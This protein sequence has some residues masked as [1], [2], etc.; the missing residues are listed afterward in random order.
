MFFGVVGFVVFGLVL[1]FFF[2]FLGVGVCVCLFFRDNKVSLV[3]TGI[4][5]F[6]GQDCQEVK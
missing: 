5:E 1:L 6:Q 2:S 3:Q 4:M